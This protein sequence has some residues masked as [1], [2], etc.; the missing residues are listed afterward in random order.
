[1]RR[2]LA[3]AGLDRVYA[4]AIGPDDDPAGL[5]DPPFPCVL[6]PA[7]GVASEDVLLVADR[8]ELAARVAEVRGRRPGQTLLVE[9]FLA[10]PLH[11]LETVGDATGLRVL[12]GFH[13]EL[14]TPPYFIEQRMTWQPELPAAV[15]DS[16]LD[17][18]RALGVGLGACHTELVPQGRRARLVEVNYRV[19]GDQCD[20]LLA[21]L[22]RLPIFELVLRAHLGE[23]VLAEIP[24][25]PGHAGRGRVE[26]AVA[27]RAGVLRSAPGPCDLDRGGVRLSYRPLRRPGER[28]ALTHTIRDYLGVLRAV[29]TDPAAGAGTAAD[30]VEA[31]VAGRAPL[32]DRA[33]TP[34]DALTVRVL[35]TLLREDVGGLRSRAVETVL[36]GECWLA[37]DDLLLPV[38][39][40]GFLGDHTVRRPVLLRRTPGGL[41]E[42][43]GLDPILAALAPRGDPEAA[44]GYA[45]FAAECRL[46][47]EVL[48]LDA[49]H[50][51]AVL[52]R[53]GGTPV[54]GLAGLPRYEALAG[55]AEH[56]V[57]PTA[58]A[59]V[60]LAVADLPRYAPEY[61]PSFAL[62][63]AAVPAAAVTRR[64]ELPACWPSAG[65]V[66]L[67]PDRAGGYALF[68][69][70]PV[71]VA[72]GK[73]PGVATLAPRP[74]LTVTPALSM[75]TVIP[76]EHPA[77]HLKLPLPMSTL[78]ARNRR[79]LVPGTLPDGALVQRLLEAVL[80]REPAYRDRILLADE[81][82]YGHAGDEYLGYLIRRYPP[83]LDRSRVVPVAALLA[84]VPDQGCPE[85]RLVIQ[86]LAAECFDGDLAGL[87]DG[88]LGLLLGWHAR[89]W[90]RYGVALEAHP[91]NVALVLDDRPG[92]GGWVRLLYKD[93]DGPRIDHDRLSAA[94]GPAAPARAEAADG[95]IW[96]A[97]DLPAV[98]TTITLHLCAAA[99]GA[100][101]ARHGLLPADT[102][103]RLVR[104]HLARAAGGPDSGPLRALL[105]AP[106][107]PVKSMVTAGTLLPKRRT[108]ASDINKHYGAT[109]PNYLLE[110]P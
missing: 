106:R 54:R 96:D 32:G 107:L 8:A 80:A 65:Q 72:A 43:A 50:R 48:R 56:P 19:I 73:L 7:E 68:P 57:Y 103:P 76:R 102:V 105:R 45:A 104:R 78:G 74:Y 90:L 62:R 30:T 53:L 61:A 49:A 71:T 101:L 79:S 34:E 15:R 98:F 66:G 84:A 99:L 40:G 89:L 63:W 58:R 81:T 42:L 14:S 37:V 75:R 3:G 4:E 24:D 83:G 35:D 17:Q 28:I 82:S 55:H 51:P 46:A 16:A 9:E 12:G 2:H 10:G 91:Q 29:G 44:E 23:A 87:L 27:E 1:M 64:G 5:P 31:A 97:A 60:G 13:T 59:R 69:V 52:A 70:H 95:R 6:K 25:R 11:T 36:A 94:L 22:L 41:A 20:L 92:R 38:R 77:T 110:A 18:L 85:G 26:Y 21:D 33:V 108:G 100:G 39:P 88:Y 47:R 86:E 93:N 109:C 67:R